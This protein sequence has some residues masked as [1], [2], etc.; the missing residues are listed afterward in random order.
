MVFWSSSWAQREKK[1]KCEGKKELAERG[2]DRRQDPLREDP[3]VLPLTSTHLPFSLCLA[4]VSPVL[5]QPLLASD[6]ACKAGLW[7]SLLPRC[8]SG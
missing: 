5:T 3:R 7:L 1:Y 4:I 6:E 8:L 2:R